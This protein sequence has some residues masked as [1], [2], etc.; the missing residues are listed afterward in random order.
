ME[1]GLCL[2]VY[3]TPR[4]LPCQHCF[5][6]NCLKQLIRN[7]ANPNG[8]FKCPSCRRK[9][10]IPKKGTTGF[11]ISFTL[12]KL[13]DAL[14]KSG[15]QKKCSPLP[16][17][18]TSETRC[19]NPTAKRGGASRG[20][21]RISVESIFCEKHPKNQLS[22]YCEDCTEAMCTECIVNHKRHAI[23]NQEEKARLEKTSISESEAKIMIKLQL[24]QDQSVLTKEKKIVRCNADE[25]IS[26]VKKRC[27]DICKQVHSAGQEI[28]TQLTEECAEMETK[29]NTKVEENVGLSHKLESCIKKHQELRKTPDAMRIIQGKQKLEQEVKELTK[30][31][32][33][34]I[35][36][37]IQ[38]RFVPG[39]IYAES[40]KDLVGTLETS[41]VISSS[42]VESIYEHMNTES[43]ASARNLPQ[44]PVLSHL[45]QDTNKLP[46][47]GKEIIGNIVIC[48]DGGEYI[49]TSRGVKVYSAAGV[50]THTIA[51]NTN[52]CDIAE[53]PGGKLAISCES[54]ETVKVFS[55]DGS[56]IH[57]IAAAQGPSGRMALLHNDALAVCY[58]KEKCVRVFKDC[59]ERAKVVSV[60]RR[61]TIERSKQQP[62]TWQQEEKEFKWSLL[63]VTA[64]GE[65]G[66]IV[67]D[68]LARAVYAFTAGEQGEYT[69]QWMYGGEQGRGPGMLD[70]PHGV[71][72]D[73]Q[74]RV[75]IADRYNHRVL[76][77]S[78]AGE[79][80]MEL[81]TQED[82]LNYPSAVAVGA[83]KL[84]L[85]NAETRIRIYNYM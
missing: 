11:P 56:Y 66:L 4:V 18:S 1:C 26:Q 8:T 14:G 55:K 64:H 48:E 69:C 84:A 58:P 43:A 57:T 9:V 2:E 31:K 68:S 24:C 42:G 40:I 62:T 22:L 70:G 81:L 36:E 73:S 27:D 33:S 54:D 59:G 52:D 79:M 77:L 41:H 82:G 28:I 6:E 83:G 21:G 46:S 75:L 71:A 63:Y 5:C 72:T 3:K 38:W 34:R 65:N 7:N 30:A 49:A 20:L 32:I 85:I 53:L 50:Y 23:I 76:L 39:R 13:Q 80:L 29:I 45:L 78:P 15:K 10:D 74:G 37:Q 16:H 12:N 19:D 51:E 61:F 35:E 60:I 47:T 44:R 25:V 67:S 17:H